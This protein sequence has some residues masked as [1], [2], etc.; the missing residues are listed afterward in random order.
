MPFE[1]FLEGRDFVQPT[2]NWAVLF[3]SDS[4]VVAREFGNTSKGLRSSGSVRFKLYAPRNAG[5]KLIRE[6]ADHLNS[7]FSYTTGD[8]DTNNGGALFMKAGSL[9]KVSDD[10]DGKLSYNLDYIYDYYTS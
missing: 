7:I 8:S 1:I 4:T 5:T 10:D 2:N 6:M 3:I 9:T